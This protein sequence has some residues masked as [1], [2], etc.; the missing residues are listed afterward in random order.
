MAHKPG[1]GSTFKINNTQL[2]M[3]F[4]VFSTLVIVLKQLWVQPWVQLWLPGSAIAN[5]KPSYSSS[6]PAGP[7]GVGCHT[8][9]DIV[10]IMARQQQHIIP[11]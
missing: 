6:Y 1:K 4:I 7:G 8:V 2:I 3:F 9:K 10:H 11:S 5:P